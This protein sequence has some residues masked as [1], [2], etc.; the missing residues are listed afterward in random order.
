MNIAFHENMILGYDQNEPKLETSLFVLVPAA[1][2][3]KGC[4]RPGDDEN[5][6]IILGNLTGEL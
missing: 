6:N 2:I 1:K 3:F 4:F 5:T